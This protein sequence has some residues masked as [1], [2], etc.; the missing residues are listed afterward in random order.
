MPKYEGTTSHYP[1]KM[2]PEER[3]I[4]DRQQAIFKEAGVTDLSVN[5]VLRHLIRRAELPVPRTVGE[6]MAELQRHVE[7]CE[8]GCQ[9]FRPP[10]CPDGLYLRELNHWVSTEGAEAP[11]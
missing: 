11:G 6:G 5:K 3:A 8:D 4:V 9:P 7:S 2:T 10:R 1:L